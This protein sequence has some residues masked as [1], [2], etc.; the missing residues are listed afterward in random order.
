MFEI[1]LYADQKENSYL[2]IQLTVNLNFLDKTIT[3]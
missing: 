2:H 1:Y 3:C